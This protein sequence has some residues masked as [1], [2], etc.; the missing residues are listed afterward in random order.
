MEKHENFLV[1][2][3]IICSLLSGFADVFGLIAFSMGAAI[4][5]ISAIP[6][7]EA[8]ARFSIRSMKNVKTHA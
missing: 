2:V 3:M 8:P 7:K 5:V 4:A 6:L 1:A